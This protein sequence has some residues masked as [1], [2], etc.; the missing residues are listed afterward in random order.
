MI[1]VY[2]KGFKR[3]IA[4]IGEF[5]FEDERHMVL[6]DKGIKVKIPHEHIVYTEWLAEAIDD[7]LTKDTTQPNEIV[8]P[9]HDTAPARQLPVSPLDRT[10]VSE[11]IK[12]SLLPMDPVAISSQTEPEDLIDNSIADA[13]AATQPMTDIRVEFVS[14]TDTQTAIVSMPFEIAGVIGVSPS[15]TKK[16][17]ESPDVRAIVNGRFLAGPPLRIQNKI[18]Y[19]IREDAA[20]SSGYGSLSEVARSLTGMGRPNTISMNMS[21]PFKEPPELNLGNTDDKIKE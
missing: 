16:I 15:I 18:T 1:K 5:L 7:F 8:E 10:Q 13:V 14:A 19:Q 12:K 4:V 17:F 3:P 6:N 20:K 2:I 9:A 21:N 11:T